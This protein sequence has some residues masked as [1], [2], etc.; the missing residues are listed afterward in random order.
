[1]AMLRAYIL[2][3]GLGDADEADKILGAAEDA[4]LD[5]SSRTWVAAIRADVWTFHGRASEGAEHI[6][7]LLQQDGLS[8]GAVVAGRT[9]LALGWTFAGRVVDAVEVAESCLDADPQAADDGPLSVRWSVLACLFAYR[10]AGRF[11]DMEALA[12]SEYKRA[13]Q[14][15]NSQAQGVAVGSLGWVSLAE[16]RLLSAINQFRESVA[17]LDE[18]DLAAV[19]TLSLA[20]LIE[21]LAL[22][23][24]PE[25]ADAAVSDLVDD[26]V[27]VTREI[28]T[29]VAISQGWV[30]AARGE[31]T[32]S[33]KAFMAAAAAARADGQVFFEMLAL[34][35]AVRLGEAQVAPRLV[36]LSKW[37]QGPI[38][39]ATARQ[40]QAMAAGSGVGLDEAADRWEALGMWL[41]AAECAAS[42]SQAHLLNGSRRGAAASASR[43]EA[44][45]DHCDGPRPLGLIV[46]VAAPALTRRE[47]EVALLAESGL[48]SQVIAER[49]Y[50]SVRTVDSHLARIYNKLGIAG[51]RELSAALGSLASP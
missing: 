38:I 26:Q 17:V 19:R 7:P 44:L 47:R 48:S 32:R 37:V 33:V 39:Q 28:A 10:W 18:S 43:A 35:S 13:I 49:L 45:L 8:P 1:V 27:P 31:L 20:G 3:W 16:G 11:R 34:H 24:D 25:G 30:S 12:A 9:A 5:P 40:A 36:A 51:R 14:L 2:Y 15:H 6:A 41:H 50:L 21:S 22:A 29:R 23:R 4:I 42:A 46:S